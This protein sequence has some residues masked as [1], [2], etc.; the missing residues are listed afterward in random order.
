MF[1]FNDGVGII[2]G[3]QHAIL[4]L[5]K[6]GRTIKFDGE[7]IR[8]YCKIV[9]AKYIADGDK[10]RTIYQIKLMPNVAPKLFIPIPLKGRKWEDHFNCFDSWKTASE[11][12]QIPIDE[13]K[14]I[15]RIEFPIT[16]KLLDE[17]EKIRQPAIILS[18]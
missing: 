3:K 8:G 14:K 12:L 4:Y 10:S 16:S 15:F 1:C 11:W 5:V 13:V 7:D 9:K 17:C 18:R 2:P 6:N